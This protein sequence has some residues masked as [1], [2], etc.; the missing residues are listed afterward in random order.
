MKLTPTQLNDLENDARYHDIG[1]LP[2]CFFPYQGR[3]DKPELK[4][5]LVRP[6][7]MPELR[8]MSRAVKL[9]EISHMARAIDLVISHDVNDL[10]IQDFYYVLA[11]LRMYSRPQVPY[12]VQWEC[13]KPFFKNKK[14]GQP[15]FYSEDSKWPEDIET[16]K[17][18]YIQTTCGMDNTFTVKDR[19]LITIELEEKHSSLPEGFDF[20]RVAIL[21]DLNN[22]LSDS[23]LSNLAS[24]IQWLKGETWAEK[25]AAAEADITKVYDGF[26]LNSTINYG[27]VET[28]QYSCARCRAKES[29]K[30]QLNALTFF[31]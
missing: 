1:N 18:D 15:L 24:G 2:S 11:W 30:L 5:L 13:N 6:L 16:L 31:R 10:T 27:V 28:L 25:V 9:D 19:D 12:L 21:D 23:D 4:R 20:P 7:E 26:A 14:T 3:S 17:R 29:H 22:A 8:L